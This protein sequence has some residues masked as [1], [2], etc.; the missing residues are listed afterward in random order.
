MLKIGHKSK[1][2]QWH[3]HFLAWS[4]R[5]RF[6]VSLVKIS[7]W[8]KFHVKD[9]TDSGAMTIFVYKGL[10]RNPEIGNIPVS[11]LPKLGKIRETKFGTNV[12]NKMLLNAAKYQRYSFYRFWV[13][14]GK[15]AWG[16]KLPP[17]FGLRSIS[18]VCCN[19]IP[20]FGV[21]VAIMLC[22]KYLSS[23][24]LP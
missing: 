9:I 7:Y 23:R 10:T 4:Y 14:K 8:S 18:Q 1:N 11:V 20:E 17:R 21:S 2:W 13:I 24:Y 19:K 3:H 22:G 5:Q 15:P 12:S 16:V 6:R